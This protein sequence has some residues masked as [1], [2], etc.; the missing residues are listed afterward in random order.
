MIFFPYNARPI[1]FIELFN[2]NDIWF[3]LYSIS[4]RNPIAT[5]ESILSV[6]ENSLSMYYAM[7]DQGLSTY[8]IATVVVHEVKE[9][10]MA[11]ISRWI[12]ENMLQTQVYLKKDQSNEFELFSR[13]GINTCVWELQILWHERNAWVKHVLSRNENPNFTD[14]CK[15]VYH[16]II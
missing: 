14:Y 11:I 6:K 4:N 1:K 3:K 15:D 10:L 5:P 9:G 13:N 16:E 12:D 2:Q 8:N 7:D